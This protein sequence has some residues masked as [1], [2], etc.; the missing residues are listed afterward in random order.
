MPVTSAVLREFAR[1]G[2]TPDQMVAAAER[3][4]DNERAMTGAERT[5]KWRETKAAVTNVTRDVTASP[6]PANPPMPEAPRVGAR[7]EPQIT[8]SSSTREKKDRKIGPSARI[9]EARTELMAVLDEE[10]AKAVVDHRSR[11][12][13]P[14]TGYAAKQLAKKFAAAPDPNAA[15]DMMVTNGWQ[16]F[17]PS[18]MDGR[19][20]QGK[21]GPQNNSAE[22]PKWQGPNAQGNPKSAAPGLLQIGSG[23]HR[24]PQETGRGPLRSVEAERPRVDPVGALL[25]RALRPD[26]YDD[27]DGWAERMA[28]NLHSSG[29]RA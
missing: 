8:N 3:I 26:T 24:P 22:L 9:D 2:M 14:L 29:S 20:A 17:E 21:A 23:V 7:A 18:W 11:L 6:P 12:K 16:G 10:R 1:M 13:K 25:H 5:R 19:G 4:E 15:A 28:G 27:G